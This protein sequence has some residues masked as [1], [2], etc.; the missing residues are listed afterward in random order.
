MKKEC[1]WFQIGKINDGKE[2]MKTKYKS[3]GFVA[4]LRK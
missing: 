4:E 2:L 3:D 1:E